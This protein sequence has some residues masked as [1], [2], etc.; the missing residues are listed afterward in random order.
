MMKTTHRPV[1]ARTA[2]ATSPDAPHGTAQPETSPTYRI[3]AIGRALDLL[4]AMARIGPA[5]LAE[6]AAE[7][8]CTRTAGF[9]V[10][11]T[12]QA[13]GFAL[14]DKARGGWRLGARLPA[15]GRAATSHGALAAVASPSLEALGSATGEIAHL[16]VRNGMAAETIAEYRPSTTLPRF[17]AVGERGPLH[18]GPGR[19]LLAY[20]PADIQAWVLAQRLPRFTPATPTDPRWIAGDLPR[21]R[22]R[23]SFISSGE[24]HA[25][26]V[27]VAAPVRDGSGEV[28]A[29]LCLAAASLR[30]RPPRTKLLTEPVIG[31]AGAVSNA[32]GYRCA[33]VADPSHTSACTPAPMT[34]SAAKPYGR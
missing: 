21:L 2:G 10:L 23:A 18:A 20:A 25:G 29:I 13:R 27:T 19:L 33:A 3:A 17:T 28:I 9:R 4:E 6:L 22:D 8:G 16:I 31:A 12:L 1:S 30:M 5:S 15:L 26:S 24:V 32:L 14:Q 11:R 7:A 34:A